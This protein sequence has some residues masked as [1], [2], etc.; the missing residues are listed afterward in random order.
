MPIIAGIM[1][2]ESARH[3]E[4]MA[5]EVP[6]V[7]VPDALRRADAARRGAGEPRAEGHGDRAGNCGRASG[8][9]AGRADVD[10]IGDIERGAGG[11]RWTSLTV[12]M[13]SPQCRRQLAG[14]CSMAL[15]RAEHRARSAER[16]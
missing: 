3:A 13:Y 1:P 16:R 11:P 8:R 14:T 9:G 7:R 15:I 2:F 4:F 12:Q 6:G 5:N 10:A